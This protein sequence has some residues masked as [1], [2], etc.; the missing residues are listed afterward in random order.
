MHVSLSMDYCV[1]LFCFSFNYGSFPIIF[2]DPPSLVERVPV[3]YVAPG[4][5]TTIE[6]FFS[7]NPDVDTVRWSHNNSEL[8]MKRQTNVKDSKSDCFLSYLYSVVEASMQWNFFINKNVKPCSCVLV[9]CHLTTSGRLGQI[10][11][12]LLPRSHRSV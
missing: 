6:C 12:G 10:A 11:V 8:N 4:Q 2:A 7:A 9:F 1:D 3:I 5:D